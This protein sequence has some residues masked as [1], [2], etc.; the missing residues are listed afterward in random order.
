MLITSTTNPLVCSTWI[1]LQIFFN[2]FQLNI[3]ASYSCY[4]IWSHSSV[5]CY[6]TSYMLINQIMP[7]R[8][9][10]ELSIGYSVNIDFI[11]V[12]L[13]VNKVLYICVIC[14]S[15][16]FPIEFLVFFWSYFKSSMSHSSNVQ[17]VFFSTENQE[18][19]VHVACSDQSHS[20]LLFGTR[21][22]TLWA[23]LK[24]IQRYNQ[25]NQKYNISRTMNWQDY[26]R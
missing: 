14:C 2:K 26:A 1:S 10:N 23:A 15:F 21:V 7:P 25:I 20:T 17:I 6:E 8:K 18:W 16:L 19:L 3:Y 4:K 11:P 24:C 5:F 13:F 22:A 12:T 9:T